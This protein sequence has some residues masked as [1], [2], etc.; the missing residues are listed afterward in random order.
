M[1][2][3]SKMA[4]DALAEFDELLASRLRDL[5]AEMAAAHLQ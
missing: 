1:E 4:E 3:I 5:K 2:R